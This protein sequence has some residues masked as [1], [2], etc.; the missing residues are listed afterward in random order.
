MLLPATTVR[1][2][3]RVQAMMMPSAM[4]LLMA[5]HGRCVGMPWLLWL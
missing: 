3:T 5:K 1:E 2:A 4:S